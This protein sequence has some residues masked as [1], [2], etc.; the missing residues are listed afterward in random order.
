MRE[1]KL[2]NLLVFLSV[3]SFNLQYSSLKTCVMESRITH[4]L[5]VDNR[6]GELYIKSIRQNESF[7]V[8]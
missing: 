8:L 4:F 7:D 6:L 3:L 2:T 1:L 5:K